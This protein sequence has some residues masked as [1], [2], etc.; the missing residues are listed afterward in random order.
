MQ[1]DIN[2]LTVTDMKFKTR[3]CNILHLGRNKLTYYQ[4]LETSQLESSVIRTTQE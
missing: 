2:R 4:R 3:N 1:K